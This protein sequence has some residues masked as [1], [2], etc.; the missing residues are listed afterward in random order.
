MAHRDNIDTQHAAVG[1]IE[2]RKPFHC[3]A[4]AFETEFGC[5][6]IF[7]RS[8]RP[9]S[10]RP[11]RHPSARCRARYRQAAAY[12]RDVAMSETGQIS[13]FRKGA[14][15]VDINPGRIGAVIRP[16]VRHKGNIQ[17]AGILKRGS[18]L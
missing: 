5:L 1:G 2:L 8:G 11:R 13:H 10:F 14:F 4:P 6:A 7:R 3:T 17:I 16:A 15:I 18:S 9:A 12:M